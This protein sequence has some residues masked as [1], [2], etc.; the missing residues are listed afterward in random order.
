MTRRIAWTLLALVMVSAMLAT[1]AAASAAAPKAINITAYAPWSLTNGQM[2][3]LVTVDST[4]AI[5]LSVKA[6]CDDAVSTDTFAIPAYTRTVRTI[7]TP[8]SMSVFECRPDIVWS[9]GGAKGTARVTA[10][11]RLI[12]SVAATTPGGVAPTAMETTLAATDFPDRWQAFP[13]GATVLL[14]APS[15][16]ALNPRQQQALVDFTRAGGTL[17]LAAD[18]RERLTQEWQTRGAFVVGFVSEEEPFDPDTYGSYS[19]RDVPG[20][21]AVPGTA[22]V[23]VGGFVTLAFLFA[24]LAGPINL[25]WAIKR[26]KQRH[27][28]WITTPALSLAACALLLGYNIVAEGLH[29]RRSAVQLSF[30]DGAHKQ[31]TTFEGVSFFAGSGVDGFELDATTSVSVRSVLTN[32]DTDFY[33]DAYGRGWDTETG[34]PNTPPGLRIDY[35]GGAQTLSGGWLAARENR[36]FAATTLHPERRRVTIGEAKGGGFEVVNGL[37]VGITQIYWIETE[38]IIWHAPRV[39]V[40]AT[41]SLRLVDEGKPELEHLVDEGSIRVDSSFLQ[42]L[43]SGARAL[44]KRAS[45]PGHFVARLEKPLRPF[46]GPEA[47]DE[48]PAEAWLAGTATRDEVTQ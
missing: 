7:L 19:H 16:R 42:R 1:T 34:T 12:R 35:R 3:I 11:P 18:A 31:A 2:V 36:Q 4:R 10:N 5:E 8:P 28:L 43:P 21:Y 23:P 40:G 47:E 39:A 6:V 30:I 46:L 9:T 27:L 14:D 26:R 15:D 20:S 48:E 25:W 45:T 17:S 24:L 32:R 41:V 33:P 22:T 37:G 44:W 13:M 29:V 38:G